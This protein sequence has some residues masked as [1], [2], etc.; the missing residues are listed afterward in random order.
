MM[1]RGSNWLQYNSLPGAKG[2]YRT[3]TVRDE[4]LQSGKVGTRVIKIVK[5]PDQKRAMMESMTSPGQPE[6]LECTPSFLRQE[7]HYDLIYVPGSSKYR[8]ETIMQTMELNKQRVLAALHPEK[9]M[10]NSDR[11]YNDILKAFRLDTERYNQQDKQP[12][13]PSNG[14]KGALGGPG[15]N[16]PPGR[17]SDQLLNRGGA[18]MPAIP[19]EPTLKEVVGG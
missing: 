14:E 17:A 11:F 5:K 9:F 15:A 16:P 19:K 8:S 3:L 2:R 1:L 6:V 18:G 13:A 4:V 7:F 12:Q 10:K